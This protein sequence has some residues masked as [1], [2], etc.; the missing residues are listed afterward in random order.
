MPFIALLTKELRSRL[1]RERTIWIIIAYILIM[2]LL[3]WIV[4]GRYTGY[5]TYNSNNFSNAGLN[6]YYLLSMIQL[7]LIL[8]ATPAFTSTAV[9]GEKERQTFDLLLCS[10][11]SSFSLVAGKLIAGLVNALLLVIAAIPLF[12]LVFLFGGVSP[13][14]VLI[15]LLIYFVTALMS[16]AFGVLCST[17]FKRPTIST[18]ITYILGAL[19]LVIPVVATYLWIITG[20]QAPSSNQILFL[21]AWHPVMAMIS[22]YSTGNSIFVFNAG[23]LKIAH[24]IM[25]TVLCLVATAIFFALS[26][27]AAKPNPSVRLRAHLRTRRKKSNLGNKATAAA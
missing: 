11:L 15:A 18:V 19:W 1:R 26:M 13:E 14:Q 27:W 12:S 16:G 25:Y 6:F 24:W 21:Y 7:F 20:N 9:N 2:S 8:F 17:I 3:G 23:W 22:S 4:V 10:Q 5:S